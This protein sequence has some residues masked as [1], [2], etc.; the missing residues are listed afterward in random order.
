M[1]RA[2]LYA[3]DESPPAFTRLLSV[4]ISFFLVLLVALSNSCCYSPLVELKTPA[5]LHA[6]RR[7]LSLKL[8][9]ERRRNEHQ[10]IALMNSSRSERH[11][12]PPPALAA[13]RRVYM[14]APSGRTALQALGFAFVA[15]RNRAGWAPG[16]TANEPGH[17]SRRLSQL[18]TP[19]APTATAASVV[20]SARPAAV[21]PSCMPPPPPPPPPTS[22]RRKGSLACAP[23]N[24]PAR[25]ATITQ[26]ERKSAGAKRSRA[27]QCDV[28]VAQAVAAGRL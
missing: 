10:V 12:P 28:V 6:N 23:N 11:T 27:R 4:S 22:R 1:K 25:K 14:C 18:L 17:L 19:T 26:L 20:A 2:D 7:L 8:M 9:N 5:L 16:C 13:S 3:S 21:S 15:V 24:P